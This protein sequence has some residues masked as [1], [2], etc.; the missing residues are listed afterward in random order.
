MTRTLPAKL[1][2]VLAW[3][4]T[5]AG[6]LIGPAVPARAANPELKV[7]FTRLRTT[8]S[9]KKATA[10]LRGTVTNVGAQPA[11]GVR[12][13]L[14]RS[15]DPITEPAAFASVLSGQNQ[16]W[17][18]ALYPTAD[19][20]FTITASDQAFDPGARAEFTVR[21]T[22]ADL[23]F[24]RAGSVYLFGVQVV[25]TADASSNYQVLARARTFYVT[26][27][28]DRLPLAS[29][30]L[31][32]ATPSMVRPGVFADERLLG[33]LNGRLNTL[34]TTAGRSGMSWLIDPA[35]IDEV[36]DMA[37]GYSVIDGDELRPGTGQ[38]TAQAWLQ[39][40]RG[41]P[42]DRGSRT[43][44][45]NPD[46]LGAERNQ[47]HDVLQRSLTASASVPELNGLPLIVLPH[48]GVADA[49]TPAWLRSADADAIAVTTAGRGP[50]VAPGPSGSTL[51]RLAPPASAAGPGAE[52]GPV[53]RAQRQYAE[54]I[55]GGGLVRLI[56]TADDATADAATSPRWL[57]RSSLRSLL[58]DPAEGPAATLVASAKAATLPPSKFRQLARLAADF[59]DYR[60]LVPNSELAGDE[61][62]TLS[63]L[64]SSNWIGAAGAPAW[65]AAV[66]GMVGSDAVSSKVV[67]SASPRVLMSSRT[68][69]F[70]VTV[71]NGLTEPIAVRVVFASDNPQRINIAD[72]APITVEPGQKQTV[73]VRP[74]TSSNGLVSVTASLQT[75]SGEPV[76]TSTRIA[77]E[78]TDLGMIGWIIVIVSGIVL[79]AT[80]ALR[81]WQVRRKQREEEL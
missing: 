19:H 61:P 58:A 32:T 14:W 31:L 30:V 38:A 28:E 12:V 10:V 4:I 5:V 71:I 49:A 29:V 11:F 44:F 79:V 17:G 78:V 80:T 43:L 55:F 41:L 1:A 73:N 74:E 27:P 51:V 42:R 7:E 2:L 59:E 15:R 47:A 52:D 60:D 70:P 3:M 67:L 48:E 64:V 46:V 22:L 23:G 50:V 33:E 56:R 24:T 68:N 76:G 9:G 18:T 65:T 35:L 81:I 21:G 57:A 16:P 66:T 26:T 62:A 6:V 36:S 63:R 39:R 13:V 54:A 69:E 25:G 20:R 37:D 34:L 40:F 8:G 53:Q 75:T 72:T 77:V 45:A